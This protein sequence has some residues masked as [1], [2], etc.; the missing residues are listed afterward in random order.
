MPAPDYLNSMII[1]Y[2]DYAVLVLV[3]GANA[4]Y[5]K[6]YGSSSLGCWLLL[7]LGIL[8]CLVLPILSM[9]VELERTR[10]PAGV[11]VDGF[12]LLYI[13]L[14]FPMY[15]ILFVLQVSFLAIYS[16]IQK[17]AAQSESEAD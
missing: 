14:R 12:E 3:V 16:S 15:W 11:M 8:F 5:I 10:R 17:Q 7:A 4:A 9:R 13:W 1:G 2:F 6:R